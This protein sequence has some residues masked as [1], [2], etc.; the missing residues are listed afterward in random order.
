MATIKCKWCSHYEDGKCMA[1]KS[2]GKHPTVKLN[3][4]RQCTKYSIDADALIEVADKAYNK[5]KIPVYAPT[6]RYWETKKS[7][8][9]MGEEKGAKFVRINPVIE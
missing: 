1:K 7:L 3:A 6:W 8:K 9:E 5:S 4:N 2:G